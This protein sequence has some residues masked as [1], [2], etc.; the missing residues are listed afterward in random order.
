MIW[1]DSRVQTRE[2]AHVLAWLVVTRAM[3]QRSCTGHRNRVIWEYQLVVLACVTQA[4]LP[5]S[6]TVLLLCNYNLL[7]L[8][9][10]LCLSVLFK[11]NVTFACT[12]SL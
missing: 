12:Q 2:V 7:A 9:S 8:V 3:L 1:V 4:T 10:V 11:S 5:V 6:C